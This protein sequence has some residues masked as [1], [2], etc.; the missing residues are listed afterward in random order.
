MKTSGFLR[1]DTIS[2]MLY[3]RVLDVILSSEVRQDA[4]CVASF[5][6]SKLHLDLLHF[7]R[8]VLHYRLRSDYGELPERRRKLVDNAECL[9]SF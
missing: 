8:W 9:P 1:I 2:T 6:T 5:G 3:S 4:L 7:H